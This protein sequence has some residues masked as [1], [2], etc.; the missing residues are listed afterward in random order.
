MG[1]PAAPVLPQDA[2]QEVKDFFDCTGDKLEWKKGKVEWLGLP[3]SP[4]VSFEHGKAAGSIDVT[5]NFPVIPKFTI[6]ASVNDAGELVVDTTNIPDLSEFK[7]PNLKKL[8]DDAVGNINGWFKKNGKKLKK[9]SYR[10]GVVTLEK[11]P[12]QAAFVPPVATE[13]YVSH[14]PAAVTEPVA[15]GLEPRRSSAGGPDPR[16]LAALLLLTVFVGG[17]IGFVGF[18]ARQPTQIAN[19]STTPAPSRTASATPTASPTSSPTLTPEP[20]ATDEPA[21]TATSSLRSYIAGICARVKHTK[22][23]NFLS[24][25]DWLMYWDGYHVHHFVVTVA[26]TNNGKPL[27]L[28]LDPVTGAWTGRLGLMSPGEKRIGQVFAVLEDGTPIEITADVVDLLGQVLAIRYP[29]EDSF[30]NACPGQ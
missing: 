25:V 28:V 22:F 13:H 5:I 11:I 30:G 14:T 12:V 4:E 3:L 8:V 6:N 27:D 20:T 17:A 15:A 1:E 29:Q 24:Y 7:L 19:A 2:P 23:G 26:G 10:K 18:G 21:P 16:V 9:A